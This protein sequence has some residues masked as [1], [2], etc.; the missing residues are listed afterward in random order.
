VNR[1]VTN[2]PPHRRIMEQPF[3]VV[4]VLVASEPPEHRLTQQSDE[5]MPTISARACIGK[6]VTAHLGQADRVIQLTIGQKSRI[7]GDHGTTES[8]PQPAVEIEPQRPARRFTRR[9]TPSSPSSI[10]NNVLIPISESPHACRK[11][12]RHPGNAGLYASSVADI[13]FIRYAAGVK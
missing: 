7:E 1:S 8:K 4:H 13:R 2:D 5:R 10:R 9:V 12:A 3:S 6:Y 11:I